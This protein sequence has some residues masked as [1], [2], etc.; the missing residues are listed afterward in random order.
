MTMVY[1]L[2]GKGQP[3]GPFKNREHGKRFIKMMALCGEDWADN[4]I[5]EGGGDDAPGHDSARM[6]FRA[7]RS[8]SSSKLRLV[9]KGH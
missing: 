5:V 7:N 8:K 6:S 4:K 3:V 9:M 2:H 1:M